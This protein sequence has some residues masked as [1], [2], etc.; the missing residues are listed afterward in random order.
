MR[1]RNLLLTS[2]FAGAVG[3]Q[4]AGCA[5]SFDQRDVVA[6]SD[7]SLASSVRTALV[8]EA[9]FGTTVNVN[10]TATDG[11]VLLTGFVDSEQASMRAEQV[12]RSITGVRAV[13]ND[14]NIAPVRPGLPEQKRP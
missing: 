8:N 12:A 5:A 11:T 2:L 13:K 1:A 7:S 14:L 3:I 9:G 10:V 4:L 6:V